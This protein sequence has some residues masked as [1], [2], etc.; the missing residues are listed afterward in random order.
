ML[1]FSVN[2]NAL[3]VTE[4][5]RP[6]TVQEAL[7]AGAMP[8]SAYLGGGTWL[9]AA[10]SAEPLILISLEKLALDSIQAT[11][12]ACVLGAT[13][14]LQKIIDDRHVPAALRS[15]AALTAS[16]TLRNMMTIGGEV[17]L[18]PADSALIPLLVAMGAE[19][20]VAG[21]KKPI[22]IDGWLLQTGGGLVLSVSIPAPARPCAVLAVSRT[23]HSPR[24]LVVAACAHTLLPRISGLSVLACDC[25]GT[26]VRL[27]ALEKSLEGGPLP[28]R[29]EME[30]SVGDGFSPLA[31]MH[32]SSLYKLYMTRVLAADALLMMAGG[33]AGQ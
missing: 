14:T 4:I 5:L 24:S 32:A 1:S 6:A 3:M 13:V 25:Q 26:M 29:E 31:D 12:K 19:I 17:S 33:K 21:K 18:H 15:A 8:G 27:A 7:K 9:N 2:Y 16:R 23:S 10:P 28:S 11:E 30:K 20:S 22:P